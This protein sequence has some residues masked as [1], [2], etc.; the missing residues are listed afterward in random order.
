MKCIPRALFLFVLQ[1]DEKRHSQR[2]VNRCHGG[3][4]QRARITVIRVAVAI[5][6]HQNAQWQAKVAVRLGRCD[7]R[8]VVGAAVARRLPSASINRVLENGKRTFTILM[9]FD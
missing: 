3:N 2:G 6:A 7:A 8:L 5:A 9:A 4:R 1:C